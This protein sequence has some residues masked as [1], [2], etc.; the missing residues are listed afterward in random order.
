MRTEHS[1]PEL[2]RPDQKLNTTEQNAIEQNR[3]QT[4]QSGTDR[5]RAQMKW[6]QMQKKRIEQNR[7]E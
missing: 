1:G 5:N 3:I 6:N 7:I 2:T 4:E